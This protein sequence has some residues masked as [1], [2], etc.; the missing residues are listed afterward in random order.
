MNAAAVSDTAR[1]HRG[2][3]ADGSTGLGLAIV[4]AVVRAH[5][6]SISLRSVPGDTEFA[7]RLPVLSGEL[8]PDPSTVAR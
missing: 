7:V 3:S 1:T 4:S 6:G 2:D 5:G 8:A